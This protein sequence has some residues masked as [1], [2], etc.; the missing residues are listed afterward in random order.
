MALQANPKHKSF[1]PPL[2]FRTN[3]EVYNPL[4]FSQRPRRRCPEPLDLSSLLRY[5]VPDCTHVVLRDSPKVSFG[6]EVEAQVEEQIE[7]NN[8]P[9]SG[10][11]SLGYDQPLLAGPSP[12]YF[13]AAYFSSTDTASGTPKF[14]FG[15]E[16]ATQAEEQIQAG[17]KGPEDTRPLSYEQVQQFGP[18]S[19]TYLS[20]SVSSN[21]GS[22][23]LLEEGPLVETFED[24][25]E[26]EYDFDSS[27]KY[28]FEYPVEDGWGTENNIGN[29]YDYG[30]EYEIEDGW[31]TGYMSDMDCRVDEDFYDCPEPPPRPRPAP[32]RDVDEP[33]FEEMCEDVCLLVAGLL[34]V[35]VMVWSFVGLLDAFGWWLT[36]GGAYLEWRR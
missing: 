22:S 17:Q 15:D 5:D 30:I 2:P 14:S 23:T 28:R 8:R 26:Y 33:D 24:A 20:A 12:P 3:N 35:G 27:V 13:K 25:L 31:S 18:K 11:S 32:R 7:A 6:K 10:S 4:L 36:S 1:T 19:P 16:P 9:G 29:A 34:L 21:A